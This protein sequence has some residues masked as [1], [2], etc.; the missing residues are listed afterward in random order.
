ML[1]ET[2]ECPAGR[3]SLQ[4]PGANDKQSLRA[5][6]AADEYLISHITE[7]QPNSPLAIFNDQF[8]ALGCT[9]NNNIQFWASDS[10]CATQA[11]SLNLQ[12]NNLPKA[13]TAKNALVS[14]DK[15][16]SDRLT[17]VIKL[18]KNLSFFEHQLQLCFKSG[19]QQVLIAGMMKHLPKNVLPLLQQYG[20][21]SRLPF[22]KKA[23]IFQLELSHS[24]DS[25][26]PKLNEFEGITLSSEAN[27]FGRDKLDPGAQFFLE[28]IKQLPRAKQV[29]DLCCG[30]GI[31]GLKYASLFNPSDVHFYDESH[32]AVHS[33]ENSWKLNQTENETQGQFH[34]N[35]GIPDNNETQ[36]DLILC[37]P[38]F[39]ELH[40]VGD[41]I[42]KRLFK[43]AKR[44][45]KRG[46]QLIV[47]G[48][49]HLGYH[50]SLKAYFKYVKLIANNKKFV[51]ISAYD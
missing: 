11:L 28:H 36:F 35:D 30:S 34:W 44:N 14:P 2:L 48:N 25:S 41:H 22:K 10:Y 7:N 1:E 12:H 47:V 39:H 5:W 18:P 32:M 46:G 15:P 38:P 26:Y 23:T 37:N 51:L 49:R 6:D 16:A 19:I 4:R 31:L 29:A 17:A 33:C 50:Q 42:A 3:F 8:G 24:K 40:T 20:E 27:V 9:L 43:D 21:V 45:L 13:I